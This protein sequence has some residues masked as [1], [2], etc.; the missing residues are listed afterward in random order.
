MIA[1]ILSDNDE[2]S[3]DNFIEEMKKTVS[4]DFHDE[5]KFAADYC[6]DIGG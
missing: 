5:V 2:I 1:N 3:K 4:K 6:I